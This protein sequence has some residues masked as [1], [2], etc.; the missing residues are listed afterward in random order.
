MISAD[1]AME[2]DI[3]IVGKGEKGREEKAQDSALRPSHIH[4]LGKEGRASKK[5]TNLQDSN[6]PF[7]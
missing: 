2:G 5:G 3:A 6:S 1:T 4:R 7:T